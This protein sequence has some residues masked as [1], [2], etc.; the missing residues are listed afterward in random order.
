MSVFQ[1]KSDLFYA[2][3]ELLHEKNYY[4]SVAHDAYYS[5][6]QLL[7]NIWLNSLNKTE[8][9]LV[10]I[11]KTTGKGSHEILISEI[12]SKIKCVNRSDFVVFNEK[13][14]QL[15]RLRVESDYEEKIHN[16]DS[17]RTAIALS[18]DIRCIL[19]KY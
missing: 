17:S 8:T 4:P 2:A 15:K 13:I 16:F 6:Y 1:N 19:K 11:K 5:C 10:V 3:A 12:E 7:K 9:D 18:N 14:G